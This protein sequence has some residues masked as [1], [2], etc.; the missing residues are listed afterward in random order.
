[1]ILE[2]CR[3][4]FDALDTSQLAGEGTDFVRSAFKND[5]NDAVLF[6]W[7]TLAAND[8][9]G[10]MGKNRIHLWRGFS[11]FHINKD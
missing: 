7:K 10:V 9:V 6:S 1:M 8:N 11:V 5:G 2:Q 3:L 4:H